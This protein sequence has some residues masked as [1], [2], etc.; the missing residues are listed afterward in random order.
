MYQNGIADWIYEEEILSSA[1]AYF[2]SPA[3]KN[4]AF[5]KFDDSHV[6]IFPIVKH[7]VQ[8][9]KTDGNILNFHNFSMKKTPNKVD[10]LFE[11]GDD[12]IEYVSYP[13]P[14]QVNP[15]ATLLVVSNPFE[16][17][18][19]RMIQLNFDNVEDFLHMPHGPDDY[20]IQ[21]VQWQNESSLFATISSRYRKKFRRLLR[22]VNSQ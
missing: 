21:H 14:G 5:I 18:K 6:D 2:W 17:Q 11:A 20:L 8:G 7:E 19:F 15:T 9:L 16:N 22:L 3:A 13:K 4:L 10:K 12:L 1:R